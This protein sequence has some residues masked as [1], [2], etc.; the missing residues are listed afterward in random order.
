[1]FEFEKKMI[2]ASK[3]LHAPRGADVPLAGECSR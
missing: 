2:I 3:L 1:M